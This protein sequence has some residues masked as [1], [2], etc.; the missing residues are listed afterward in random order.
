M[1]IALVSALIEEQA[2]LRKQLAQPTEVRLASRTFLCGQLAGHD[3]V[4]ALSGIGKVAAAITAS[5]L[6]HHFA[7]QQL[8]FTGVAGGLHPDAKVGDV[9]VATELLQHDMDATPLAPRHVVPLTGL[10]RFPADAL[11]SAALLQACRSVLADDAELRSHLQRFHPQAR[12]SVHQG[13]LL[14]G[15]QFVNSQ[16]QSQRLRDEL[17]DAWAVEMEGAAVAQVCH[18]HGTPFAV[19][20][21]ISDRADATAHVDFLA[22]V[23]GVASLYSERIV[24]E[25]LQQR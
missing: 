19:M 25:W 15:D 14:S 4:F 24:L 11:L 2:S 22:F 10:S 8:V 13:L 20:R 7:A 9:V 1:T 6:I 16:T 12:A 21:T 5:T 23:R 17:P 18:D 3:V